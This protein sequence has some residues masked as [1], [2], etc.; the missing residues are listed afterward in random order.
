MRVGICLGATASP[1]LA[2][3]ALT[4]AARRARKPMESGVLRTGE[5]EPESPDGATDPKDSTGPEAAGPAG[6]SE[7]AQSQ[8]RR[9]DGTTGPVSG[10]A[11]AVH[12]DQPAPERTGAGTAAR[13][14][15]VFTDGPGARDGPSAHRPT[16]DQRRP[17]TSVAGPSRRHGA[18]AGSTRRRP[19]GSREAPRSTPSSPAPTPNRTRAE[20]A[21]RPRRAAL[22]SAAAPPR[23]R[24]APRPPRPRGPRPVVPTRRRRGRPGVPTTPRW[25]SWESR[26]PWRDP[27]DLPEPVP[28]L[29]A[30]R[31]LPR[32]PAGSRSPCFGCC[33]VGRG[34]PQPRLQPA[35]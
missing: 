26:R 21:P 3:L 22:G 8:E 33:C 34:P 18:V 4:A 12:P 30:W 31:C 16:G 13:G 14:S 29:D 7:P 2:R 25:P 11:G 10:R 35:R 23:W 17:K 32:R 15:D 24:A 20:R 9:G 1:C 27:P 19:S 5:L 6:A 28:I